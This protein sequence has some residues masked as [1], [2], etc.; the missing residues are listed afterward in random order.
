MDITVVAEEV[1][2]LAMKYAEAAK[3]T[4]DLI[5][6][7]VENTTNGV[8]LNKDVFTILNEIENHTNNV[9]DVMDVI[10]SASKNQLDGILQVDKMQVV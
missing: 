5:Q 2:D 1:R 6:E 3:L 7:S 8:A 4:T 9:N 10:E